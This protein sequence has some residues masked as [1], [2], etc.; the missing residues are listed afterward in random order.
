MLMNNTCRICA[1]AGS[2][3]TFDCSEGMFGLGGVF[4]YFQCSA[5]GCLQIAEVPHDL[6]RFYPA[7]YYS[8]QANPFPQKG[9]KACVAGLRDYTRLIGKGW[10]SWCL[11]KGP[12]ARGDFAALGAIRITPK[13]RILDLGCGCGQLLS[14]LHR[15][16]FRH[17]FGIDPYL[18]EDREIV[19]GLVLRKQFLESVQ[20]KFDIIMLHHVF[21][22][23]PDGRAML[24]LCKDRLLGGGKILLRIPTVDSMAWEK[25]REKWVQLDAPRHLFLHSRSSL[26]MLANQAGLRIEALWCDSW[27]FQFWGSELFKRGVPLFQENGEPVVLADHF[28]PSELRAFSAETRKL[29]SAERGDQLVAILVPSN[30]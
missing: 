22:H 13:M 17:L 2:H 19:P 28:S 5:C 1:S 24:S 9:I 8:M 12:S 29:N 25:Y 18:S 11:P 14:L 30:I 23:I 21:E 6:G 7:E 27:V 10:L 4:S 3:Q 26:S 16:G 20:D 15:A